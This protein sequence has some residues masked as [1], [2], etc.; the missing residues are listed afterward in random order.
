MITLQEQASTFYNLARLNINAEEYFKE[1]N[2]LLENRDFC[3][4]ENAHKSKNH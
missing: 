4:C 1:S 2:G 3:R